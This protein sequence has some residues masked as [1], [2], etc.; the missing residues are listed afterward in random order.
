MKQLR[1]EYCG[2]ILAHN[3]N[4]LQDEIF[5]KALEWE[6]KMKLS[7]EGKNEQDSDDL[8]LDSDD[9]DKEN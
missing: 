8:D 2:K 1:I 6:E 9:E 4:K 5:H 3:E 7:E